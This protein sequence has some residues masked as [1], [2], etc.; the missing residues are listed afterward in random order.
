MDGR[1]GEEGRRK[2]R[3]GG[4]SWK[5]GKREKGKGRRMGTEAKV[6]GRGMDERE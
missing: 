6:D 5:D 3:M 2:K 4:K 1:V